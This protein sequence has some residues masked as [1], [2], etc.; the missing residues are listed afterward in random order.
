VGGGV[1]I[2]IIDLLYLESE[3]KEKDISIMIA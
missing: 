1:L 3:C 2:Y